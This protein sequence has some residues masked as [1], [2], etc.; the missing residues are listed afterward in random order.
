MS[1]TSLITKVDSLAVDLIL[2]LIPIVARLT[3]AAH[4]QW[5]SFHCGVFIT[6]PLLA[7]IIT[8]YQYILYNIVCI[9]EKT[10]QTLVMPLLA[11]DSP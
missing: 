4:I 8:L 9:E 6:I 1:S 7:V 10:E 2:N 5:H 11:L 3:L